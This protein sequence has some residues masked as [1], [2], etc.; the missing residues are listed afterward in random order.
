MNEEPYIQMRGPFDFMIVVNTN[1][2]IMRRGI[3]NILI[4]F[5]S[6]F[7]QNPTSSV[8]DIMHQITSRD[9]MKQQLV[10]FVKLNWKKRDY[11]NSIN[12]DK[13]LE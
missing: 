8:M 2:T 13:T 9:Y 6:Y 3:V 5:V 1:P 4:F 12:C 11:S 10:D 7:T